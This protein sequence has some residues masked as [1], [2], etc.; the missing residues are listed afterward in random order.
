MLIELLWNWATDECQ[1]DYGMLIV[2][3]D[4]HRLM[5]SEMDDRV[6]IDD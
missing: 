4:W 6:V 3:V 1:T 5:A 2:S